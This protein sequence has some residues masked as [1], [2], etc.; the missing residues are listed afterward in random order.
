VAVCAFLAWLAIVVQA[1]REA[2]EI[3]VVV[4]EVVGWFAYRADGVA[5][6]LIVGI[7]PA[8]IATAHRGGWVPTWLLRWGWLAALAGVLSFTP[9]FTPAPL[10]VALLVVPVGIGWTLA[11]GIV[12]LRVVRQTV[13]PTN[14]G[15]APS[16]SSHTQ[17]TA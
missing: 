11:A 17:V 9:Y 7:G 16:P 1:T 12:L 15:V 10:G 8:M 5:T 2:G 13:N 6:A 4:A 3:Q 14:A